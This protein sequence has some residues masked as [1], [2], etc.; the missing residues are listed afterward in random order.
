MIAEARGVRLE[1]ERLLDD[2]VSLRGEG[3]KLYREVFGYVRKYLGNYDDAEDVMIDIQMRVYHNKHK[4][5]FN[6]RF[7]PWVFAIATNA[8]IDFQRR[9]K[10]WHGVLKQSQMAPDIER[11]YL[12]NYEHDRDSKEPIEIVVEEAEEREVRKCVDELPYHLRE[13]VKLVY[14]QGFKYREAADELRIPIGTV[15]SRLHSALVRLGEKMAA[16]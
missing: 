13:P 16:A 7:R 14:Y 11:D 1:N 9:N 10:R 4:Y 3:R 15:K 6:K 2:F 12:D 8:S 5:D